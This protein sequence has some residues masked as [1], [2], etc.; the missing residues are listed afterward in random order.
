M[1]IVFAFLVLWSSSAFSFVGFHCIPSLR[2]TRM[3]VL[4][5]NEEVQVLVVNPSGYAFMPQFD[6]PNSVFNISFN[7][8]QGEDLK[9]LGDSF[10]FSWP[11]SACQIDSD[12]F[13][14]SCRSEAKL[15][16]NGIKA[17]G[18]TTTEVIE[19]YEGETYEKRKFRLSLEQSNIYFVTLQF[20]TKSCAKFN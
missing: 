10:F 1:K 15:A 19:K 6:G 12:K 4:V 17:F 5:Q 8:M 2:E 13:T 9:D 7:K 14:V 3:Q 16:V 11:K 20:D 18:L